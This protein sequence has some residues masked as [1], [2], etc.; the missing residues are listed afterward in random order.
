M[1][2]EE[3]F[4]QVSSHVFR[5]FADVAFQTRLQVIDLAIE[6]A[7]GHVRAGSGHFPERVE[8]V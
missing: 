6:S 1:E 7:I 4:R 8:K 3:R 2:Q 5:T